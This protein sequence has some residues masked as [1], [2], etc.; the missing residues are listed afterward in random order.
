MA[1]AITLAV[2]LLL[3]ALI[4]RFLGQYLVG[5]Y[6]GK[7]CFLGFI[8]RPIYRML[9]INKDS[10]QTWQRYSGALIIF[11]SVSLLFSYAVLRLQ[12]HLPFNPQHLGAVP[13]ALSW[14]TSVSFVT[15]TNWQN[16]AGETTM[17]YFSQ[18]V[19]LT[20]QQFLSAAAGIAVAV[21]LIRGFARKNVSTIG[22]FWVDMIRGIF[23]I[24]L[25]ISFLAGLIFVWQGSVQTLGGPALITN[26][27]TGVTQTIARGP[28]GF[29]EAIKEFGTNGGGFFNAN[30]SHPFENPT[31]LTA[32]LSIILL[33]SVPVALTYTFGKMVGN[34][35]QGLALLAAVVFIFAIWTGFSLKAE[36][37]PNPAVSAAQV[38]NQSNGNMVGKETRFGSNLTDLYNI[39]STQTSTGSVSGSND[40]FTPMGGFW[41][42]TGMML[43]E[44]TPGGVGSG[45]YT[46]L[47][48]ALIAVFLG[49][50]M[51]GRTPEYLGKK[52]QAKE[53]K[54]AAFG[55]LVMPIT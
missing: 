53:V 7:V 36:A 14:N 48:F 26:H 39:S 43:G 55:I 45:L 42:L 51:V 15:N 17:S 22:N 24:F 32:F 23:Y 20:V 27:L 31:A 16:Y 21:A 11:S 44:V 25:P 5:V 9:G 3:L 37:S 12:G 35:K 46:L 10:E 8:E 19:S 34:I 33:L 54:L 1:L 47:L 18:M 30:G 13:Q 40:S 41:L 29:M 28:A 2:F 38:V 49:G 6:S 52:I 50:L 4:W